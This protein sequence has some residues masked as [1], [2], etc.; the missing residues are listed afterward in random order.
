M[1]LAFFKKLEKSFEIKNKIRKH[2]FFFPCWPCFLQNL[3]NYFSNIFYQKYLWILAKWQNECGRDWFSNRYKSCKKNRKKGRSPT[4][5]VENRPPFYICLLLL[6][7]AT[8]QRCFSLLSLFWAPHSKNTSRKKETL[9]ILTF[10]YIGYFFYWMYTYSYQF[11]KSLNPKM[12]WNIFPLRLNPSKDILCPFAVYYLRYAVRS[13][14]TISRRR[15]KSGIK[16][17]V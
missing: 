9:L 1:T 13:F 14:F 12:H 10:I 16:S 4:T 6:L 7:G 3:Q 8:L 5:Y 2:V 11:L 15:Q 17:T